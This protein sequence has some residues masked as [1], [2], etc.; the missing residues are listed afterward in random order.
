[1][2]LATGCRRGELCGLRWSALDPPNGTLTLRAVL[3][4]VPGEV[5]VKDTETHATRRIALDP[6]TI[7]VFRRQRARVEDRAG[8][9]GVTLPAMAYVWSQALDAS[10][11]YRPDRVTASFVTVRNRLGLRQL[12]PQTCRQFAATSLAGRC[13]GMRTI[14]G[15]LGHANPSVTL[16]T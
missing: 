15:R 7:E 6:S 5:S 4:D 2:A 3:A 9:A 16:K 14:A 8:L 12:T 1:M 11:P 13:I 10:I